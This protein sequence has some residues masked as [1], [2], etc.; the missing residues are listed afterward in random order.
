MNKTTQIFLTA[1][2][3]TAVSSLACYAD[4]VP[5][6]PTYAELV[7]YG[8]TLTE[9]TYFL[10]SKHTVGTGESSTTTYVAYGGYDGEEHK[11][12][13]V[14]V[15]PATDGIYI[16]VTDNRVVPIKLVSLGNDKWYIMEGDKYLG[17]N[18]ETVGSSEDYLYLGNLSALSDNSR[19]EWYFLWDENDPKS[20]KI[21]NASK[22]VYLK[23]DYN[24][25]IAQSFFRV[26][27]YSGL[28]DVMLYKEIDMLELYDKSDNTGI[29][30]ANNNK[31]TNVCLID[32]TLYRDG[33]WNTLCLPF[34]VTLADSPLADAKVKK[35][36]KETNDNPAKEGAYIDNLDNNN[37]EKDY[38]ILHLTFEDEET[39]LQAGVPY[40]VKWDTPAATNL[41]NPVFKGVTIDY[42]AEAQSRMT[43]SYTDVNFEGRYA[44]VEITA[45][46]G[47]NTKLYLGA[48]NTYY[49]P[50]APMTIGAQ[51]AIFQLKNGYRAAEPVSG[52]G[53]RIFTPD[54]KEENTSIL[55]L[56]SDADSP[57][58]E[59]W[60]DLQG[61]SF[62]GKPTTK[63]VYIHQGK[64]VVLR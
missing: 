61:R 32:R 1:L 14:V 56:K 6:Y 42:N 47:D 38:Y 40:I 2:V 16:K 43:F 64:K 3:L 34:D 48:S 41:V 13:A 49:Y 4:D 63:G 36:V 10:A 55:T 27:D 39:E 28:D 50:N 52:G 20:L 17:V 58:S 25:S 59:I 8:S 35:L 18:T 15:T 51:R 30:E 57:Q 23:Y 31:N 62:S 46:G 7:T 26:Y 29:I 11:G 12:N 9:G 33:S 44:P 22:T 5:T 45:V 37:E 24:N 21:R 60:Y 53:V 54:F 19:F